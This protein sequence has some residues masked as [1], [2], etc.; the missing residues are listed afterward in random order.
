M[1][2]DGGLV[3]HIAEIAGV[4][5]CVHKLWP[6]GILYG[7]DEEP[8]A[9]KQAR[10]REKQRDGGR[11][12]EKRRLPDNRGPPPRSSG[13]SRRD[14]PGYD[15]DRR[16][17]RDRERDGERYGYGY[18]DQSRHSRRDRDGYGGRY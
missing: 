4:F 8:P 2:I 14:R 10:D 6:K 12:R 16:R 1:G 18:G 5:F 3:L 13:R 15:E 9:P 7:E 11:D 17:R